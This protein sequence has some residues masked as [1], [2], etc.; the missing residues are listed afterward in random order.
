[1]P[2]PKSSFSTRDA[3]FESGEG[4]RPAVWGPPLWH[5]LYTIGLNYPVRPSAAQKRQY[6]TFIRSLQF[7]LP[8]GTCRNN[9]SAN[10]QKMGFGEAHLRQSTHTVKVYSSLAQTHQENRRA[11][12]LD[13][14]RFTP[15]ATQSSPP[16][17]NAHRAPKTT[18]AAQS[19]CG[20]CVRACCCVSCLKPSARVSRLF[21][22]REIASS[23]SSKMKSSAGRHS[24]FREKFPTDDE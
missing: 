4:F 22:F 24:D 12:E 11:T 21:V 3:D 15:S 7:V 20:M 13:F 8:C 9:L 18:R 2:F 19:R 14:R 10:L 17:Q 5:V 1:M 23:T 6:G 16:V